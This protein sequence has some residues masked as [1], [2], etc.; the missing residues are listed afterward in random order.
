MTLR[1]RPAKAEK[2]KTTDRP[3]PSAVQVAREFEAGQ[4][5]I[6]LARKYGLP[7]LAIQALIREAKRRG[8]VPRS[9]GRA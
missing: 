2:P 4:S 6:A 1:S 8:G 5:V 7:P 3:E 9:M